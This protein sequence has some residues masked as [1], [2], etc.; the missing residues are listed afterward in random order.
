MTTLK[1]LKKLVSVIVG[2]DI[3][4]ADVPGETIPEVIDYLAENYPGGSG[5]GGTVESL[6]VTTKAGSTVGTAKVTVSPAITSGNSY[7]YKMAANEIVVPEYHEIISGATAWDGTSDIEGED[8]Y[9]IGIYEVTS[10]RKVVKFGQA[11]M[12]V[13]LG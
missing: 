9:R 8:G 12:N 10:D 4:P 6:T 13:N 1:S 2:A 3:A 7:V 5:G 11:I